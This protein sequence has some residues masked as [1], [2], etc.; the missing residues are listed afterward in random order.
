MKLTDREWNE[1]FIGGVQGIFNI[2]S[3]ASGIDKN[4]LANI[5]ENDEIPYITRSEAQNGIN[6]FVCKSQDLKYQIDEGNVITIGLDTQT[7]FYQPHK[8][9]TGQNIQILR[10][11][12]LNQF[13][14]LFIIPLLKIQMKKFNWGGNG[15]TLGRLLRTKIMLPVNIATAEPDWDFMEDYTKE[16]MTSK[17]QL[18]GQFLNQSL[19]ELAYKEIVPLTDKKWGEFYLNDIFNIKPGKRLTKNNMNIGERPFVGSTSS[20]NGITNFVSNN[21]NSLDSNILGVNY[22]GSVCESF[23]HPYECLFSDDVKRLSLKNYDGNK[24][25]YLFF[26]SIIMKQKNKYTYGYK[27]NENRMKRQIIMVPINDLNEPDYEYM[28]QYIKNFLL[29]KYQQYNLKIV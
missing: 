16:Q 20:N 17:E 18:Y 28:E 11:A 25:V 27:F 21:N 7:V 13:N 8:F 23:Y 2:T 15:A 19:S 4:K 10:N 12:K 6:T 1:F 9:Y 14:A 3:T 24:F 5:K 26:K 29:S 22:N